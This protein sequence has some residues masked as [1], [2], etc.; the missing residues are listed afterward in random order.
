M[1]TVSFNG[2][3]YQVDDQGFLI[4]HN[5]WDENFTTGMARELGMNDGLSDQQWQVI[6]FIRDTFR[7][8]R[9][10]P[11]VYKTC[12]EFNLDSNKMKDLFPTGYVRGACLLAGISYVWLNY[13]GHLYPA[14]A[15]EKT[16]VAQKK[17]EKEKTYRINAIGFLVDPEEWD[18][19]F[20]AN[21]AYELNIKNGLTERH[22]QVISSMRQ[23]YFKNH[24]LPTVYECC[25]ANHMDFVDLEKLFPT[26]YHRGAV[27][28]AGLPAVIR[29][30]DVE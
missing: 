30:Q 23:F 10:C 13:Y 14:A 2:R 20:A 5:A 4:D 7:K 18:E 15:E 25:N 28:I 27:K 29:R 22:R 21:R 12:Q 9:V 24:K 1:K 19:V 26:G 3:S 6:R 16:A 11:L 8:K 17:P